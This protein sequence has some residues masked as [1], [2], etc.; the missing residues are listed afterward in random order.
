MRGLPATGKHEVCRQSGC[1]RPLSSPG[2]PVSFLLVIEIDHSPEGRNC[3]EFRS[4]TCYKNFIFKEVWSY[5]KDLTVFIYSKGIAYSTYSRCRTAGK[6]QIQRCI[7]RSESFV[8]I[9]CNG[10]SCSLKSCCHRIAMQLDRVRIHCFI[11][12]GFIDLFRCRYARVAYGA[13]PSA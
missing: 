6:E 2:A 12:N 4:C 10:L 8:K 13:V 9:I 5:S 11:A 1:S 7:T 3:L